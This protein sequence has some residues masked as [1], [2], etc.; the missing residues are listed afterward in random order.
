MRFKREQLSDID[1]MSSSR[2]K[3]VVYNKNA[4]YF[5]R[6][7]QLLNACWNF[8]C[9]L[10]IQI[11]ENVD[12]LFRNLVVS[13]WVK[14]GTFSA[15][16]QKRSIRGNLRINF[17]FRPFNDIGIKAPAKTA[18]RSHNHITEFICLPDFQKRM[19]ALLVFLGRHMSQQFLQSLRIRPCVQQPFLGSP[20]FC[21]SDHLHGFG[22][23]LRTFDA[24][25]A[26]FYIA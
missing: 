2:L 19:T 23:L 13:P 1:Y 17:T 26:A 6:L 12:I 22:N 18:V 15:D 4:I 7:I 25:N 24:A 21:R 20:Q 3:T 10:K 14:I 5:L 9:V 8:W 16:C 11:F